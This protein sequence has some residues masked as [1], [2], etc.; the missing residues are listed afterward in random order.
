L[1]RA[2]ASLGVFAEVADRR[3]GLTRLGETL[4]TG[5]PSA[6]RDAVLYVAGDRA[7]KAWGELP[8]VVA[9]GHTAMELAF[10]TSLFDYFQQH[11]DEQASF[12]RFMLNYHGA[13]PAA[14]VDAYDFS[15][16]E[17]IVDVGG[18]IGTLLAAVLRGY[19]NLAGVL[20]DRPE[21]VAQ[22]RRTLADAGVADRCELVGGDFFEQ[23]PSGADAYVL[24]HV[25]NSFDDERC[26]RILRN[27]ADAMRPGATLLLI[28]AVVPPGDEP[29][30][31]KLL[32]V[33]LLTGSGG[34]ERTADDYTGLLARAGFRLTAVVGTNSAAS[35]IEATS[36]SLEA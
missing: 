29:H 20:F 36:A 34:M 30:P 9:T 2:L 5:H 16:F 11:P 22:A 1:L 8:R 12:N 21:V 35:V 25:M 17:R 3:F 18:G 7:W 10:G 19:P 27:C 24:S 6:G 14:V 15:G 32:D 31:A 13:E 4:V 26:A 33:A 28:E 23:V